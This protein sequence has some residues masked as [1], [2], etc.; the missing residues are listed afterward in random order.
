MISPP[1][2]RSSGRSSRAKVKII[3]CVPDERHKRVPEERQRW[4]SRNPERSILVCF[5]R[6]R[7]GQHTKQRYEQDSIY[8]VNENSIRKLLQN[9]KTN[10]ATGL[11]SIPAVLL[12]TGAEELAP[13][14]TRL[15]QLSLDEG[16]TPKQ[17]KEVWVTPTSRREINTNQ[18][19]TTQSH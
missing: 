13:V 6:G 12:K 17:W 14:L 19:S 15:F 4:K 11:D 16:Q 2:P 7:H 10:M 9:L 5:H 1:D 8:G 3:R 18:R